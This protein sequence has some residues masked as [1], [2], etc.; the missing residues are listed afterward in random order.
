MTALRTN[1]GDLLEPIFRKI[2]DDK[3][4]EMP[5]VFPSIFH[6]LTSDKME[7]KDSA[8]TGFGYLVETDENEQITYEDPVLMYSKTYTHKKY[9]LG[10][11]V[12]E[13]M[14]EDDLY[15]VMN[16]KP[17]KLALSAR[18]T[19]ENHASSVLNNAFSTSYLGGDGRPLCSY[20]H[21][22]ADGGTAQ[23]NASTTGIT[24]TEANLETAD[25][26]MRAQLDDKGMKIM[27]KGDR[28]LVPPALD[29]EARII[30]ES[31]MR[32]GTADNDVNVYRGRFQVQSWDYLTSTTA[33][34]LLDG[35]NH[36]L[37]WFWR[38]RPEFKNDSAFNVGAA[39]FKV[40]AR[41][42]YGWSD[43]RGVWGSKGDG[44]AYA[45]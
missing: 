12:S 19:A 42:S 36:E 21:P 2:F 16:K 25:L 3:F 26:A 28:L 37:N 40:R 29:K 15:N 10:F 18:R 11:K 39:V 14:Y 31:T 7:E 43:W 27:V 17:A 4:Q 30:T 38:V 8:V 9:T 22:R 41:W 44:A 33:W 35:S 6:V 1:F 23:I 45:S 13:E 34:F 20:I 5:E 32:S 24:L